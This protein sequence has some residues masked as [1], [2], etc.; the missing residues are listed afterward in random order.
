[1][2]DR[3]IVQASGS[4]SV[5]NVHGVP[6]SVRQGD[7]FYDDDP[8]VTGRRELFGEVDVRDSTESARRVPPVAPAVEMAVAPPGGATRGPVT[9]PGRKLAGATKGSRPDGEV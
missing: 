7:L 4:F 5:S 8:I 1:M 3:R 9:A 2:T 6:I